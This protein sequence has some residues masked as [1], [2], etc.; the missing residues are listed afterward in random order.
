[1]DKIAPRLTAKRAM[2]GFPAA[3]VAM[4]AGPE[5]V[6]D[7]AGL[8]LD[9]AVDG[10]VVMEGAAVV[11]GASDGLYVGDSTPAGQCQWSS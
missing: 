9:R 2:V 8:V 6:L 1:M 5:L 10:D 4:V 3:P 7:A 11:E